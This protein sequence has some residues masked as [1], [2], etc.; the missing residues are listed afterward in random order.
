MYGDLRCP[1]CGNM[2]GLLVESRAFVLLKSAEG[3]VLGKTQEMGFKDDSLAI[4][5]KCWA[6]MTVREALIAGERLYTI[7]TTSE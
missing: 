7:E 6:Q 2:D 4:C 5:P 3:P 1:F